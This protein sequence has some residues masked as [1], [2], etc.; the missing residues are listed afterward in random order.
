MTIICHELHAACPPDRIWALLA[1]LEAVERYNPGVRRARVQG[2]QRTGVG[3]CRS[4]ELV[5]DGRVVES[6]THWEDGRAL[7]LEV[8]ESG[9][10]IHF[11]RW[12]TRLDPHDNGTRISQS[13]E[14]Q[15]KFGPVGWLLDRV[16]MKRKLTATLDQVFASLVDHAEG[17]PT[18]RS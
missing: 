13:L 16:A 1:D 14:Y 10:P 3:A 17:A 12:V 9:W 18:G 7:G 2:P 4:C 15:V 6:V 5:P 8:V 11:M